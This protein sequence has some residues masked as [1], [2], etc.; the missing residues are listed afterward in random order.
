MQQPATT[1]DTDTHLSQDDV[2]AMVRVL[3]KISI[4]PGNLNEK[5]IALMQGLCELIDAA[6]W[7]WSV[8]RFEKGQVPIGLAS[9]HNMPEKVFS[10]LTSC[11]YEFPDNPI[12]QQLISNTLKREHWTRRREEL[13]SHTAF[14][15]SDLYNRYVK[16]TQL[17]DAM[18]TS[19]PL[20]SDPK[21]ASGISVHR[22][23][24]DPL[25]SERESLI[26][27]IATSEISWLHELDHPTNNSPDHGTLPPRLQTVF[28]LLMDGQTPKRIA[29]HL[30]LTENTVRTY[31]RHIYKHFGVSGR[32]ELTRRFTHGNGNHHPATA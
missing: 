31:I 10:K 15:D 16:D 4:M 17:G 11:N 30:G 27:H 26:L 5:R 3:G 9:C 14:K 7:L 21:L 32:L 19:F 12:K 24:G 6:Y 1:I 23:E 25:F 18:F 2:R 8:M 29:H 22:R 28:S 13:L 20:A